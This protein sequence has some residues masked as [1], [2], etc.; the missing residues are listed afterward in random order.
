MDSLATVQPLSFFVDNRSGVSG[1]LREILFLFGVASV[2]GM[3]GHVA[4]SRSSGRDTIR[5]LRDFD[6]QIFLQ[7]H[8]TALLAEDDRLEQRNTLTKDWWTKMGRGEGQMRAD[9]IIIL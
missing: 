3:T 1:S 8:N 5:L 2:E 9:H 4:L 7:P 6:P